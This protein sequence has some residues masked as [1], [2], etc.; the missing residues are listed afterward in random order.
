MQKE[1]DYLGHAIA[2]PKRPF[3]A[4]LGG[5][6]IS[7]KIDVIINLLGKVDKLIIGGGMAFTF[8]KAQGK[9]IGKSLL[10]EE[11]L[12]LAKEVLLKAKNSNVKFLLPVDFVVA[13][14]F[15]NE[16][17]SITVKADSIPSNKMGL[18]IG[19]E[20]IK[21]FSQELQNSK[22]IV[23]NGPMGVFEMDNFAKGTFSIAQVLADVTAKN[24][25]TIIGGGDSAAAISKAGLDDKVSHVSTGGGASLE[26]LEGK[27]LP[28]VDALTN[29]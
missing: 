22:T 27:I 20:S 2:N 23:W 3:T 25:V 16:S 1:L 18:D 4:V 10:E 5:A 29:A 26:F 12:E 14:E 21:L 19:P 9:E 24:A 15:K 17:P 13:D 7:G 6:K 28:G 8:L 11:K